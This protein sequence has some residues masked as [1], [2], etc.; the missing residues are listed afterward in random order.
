MEREKTYRILI[1]EDD[2]DIIKVLRLYLEN[3]GYEVRAAQN[4]RIAADMLKEEPADLG[5]FDI[6][7]PE[8]DGYELIREV[9]KTSDMPIIVL[10]AK[11]E[12][13]DKIIG[14]D[15]GADDY[16]VKP[17]NP[18]E[19][20]ARVRAQLRRYYRMGHG[21]ENVGTKKTELKSGDLRIDLQSLTLYKNEE[22]ISLT[23][24]E[25]K[26]LIYLMQHPGHVFTKVQIGKFVNM[27]YIGSD[28]NSL[29]VHISNLR[30]KIEDDPRHPQYLLT[31]RG[32]GYKFRNPEQ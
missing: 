22:E 21:K 20:V 12:D 29:M 28:D 19:I 2:E 8:M 24:T 18:L 3:E 6:M 17:F 14:L 30:E 9:R 7:M 13:A 11:Q 10:S 25:L 4:G 32:L 27:S 26:I 5:I 23:P 31:V 15:L 1:A 16:L